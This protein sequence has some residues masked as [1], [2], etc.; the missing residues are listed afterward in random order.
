MEQQLDATYLRPGLIERAAAIGIV[1][2]GT[3]IGLLLAAWGI[4]L[5]WRHTSP[6]IAVRIANPDLHVIQH[7]PFK[8]EQDK[9]FVLAQSEPLKVDPAKLTIK[10]EQPAYP[11]VG[12][13]AASDKTATGDVIRREVTVFSS[14]KHGPGFV[15][16]GWNYKDGSGG[17]PVKQFCYY[18]GRPLEPEGRHRDQSYSFAAS[19]RPARPRPGRRPGKMPV[20]AKLRLHDAHILLFVP[21]AAIAARAP[22]SAVPNGA[23]RRAQSAAR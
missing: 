16:T 6:E 13:V 23:F 18:T 4:S 7:A 8:V 19:R 11:L 21:I 10:A 20:V 15:M 9:P 2:A 1:A 12:G 3:G 5:L 22:D 14:V 17:V